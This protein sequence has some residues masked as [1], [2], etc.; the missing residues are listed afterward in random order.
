MKNLEESR[1][2][3]VIY[4]IVDNGKADGYHDGSDDIRE[5]GVSSHLLQVAAQLL[6]NNGS[7]SRTGSD[8]TSENCLHENQTVS[9]EVKAQDNPYDDKNENHL[10]NAHPPMPL[11]GMQ[12]MVIHLAERNKENQEH[13]QWEDGVKDRRKKH[14]C[15]IKSRNKGKDEVEQCTHSH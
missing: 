11:Y 2:E 12:L 10:E 3:R 7:G 14:R 13:E 6:R 9:L 5:K 1:H 8:D 15:P 4:R